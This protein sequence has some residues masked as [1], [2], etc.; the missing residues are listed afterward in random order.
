MS[1]ACLS[2]NTPYIRWHRFLSWSKEMCCSFLITAVVPGKVRSLDWAFIKFRKNGCSKCVVS[3]CHSTLSCQPVILLCPVSLSLYFVI[4]A[5]HSTSSCQPVTLL[6]H[7]S[8][9][10]YFVVS[11]CHS[12]SSCQPV[13]LLRRVSLSLYFACRI[14]HSSLYPFSIMRVS[15]SHE[16]LKYTLCVDLPPHLYSCCVF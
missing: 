11:A 5:C 9:S 1:H 16:V 2:F 3:A 8:M 12:T 15:V 6:C 4:S 10:L 7:I 14:T 13:T